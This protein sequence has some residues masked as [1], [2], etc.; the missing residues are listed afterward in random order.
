MKKAFENSL[1]GLMEQNEKIVL[2]TADEHSPELT[3]IRENFPLR[4]FSF[5]IAECNMVGAAAGL[6]RAGFVPLVYTVASFLAFRSFEFIR[7]DICINNFKVILVGYASGVKINNFGSVHHAIE[8]IA[9]L[10]ALPN[11]TLLSPASV[12]EVEPVLKAAL[13]TTAP[14]YIRLGK[15][16]EIE[17]FDAPPSFTIGKSEV[18]REGDDITIISTGNIISNAVEAAKLLSESGIEVELINLSSIKPLDKD[19]LLNSIRKTKHVLTLEEH[20]ITG[21]IGSLT[22][23]LIAENSVRCVFERMGFK[24]RFVTEYGWHKEILEQNGLSTKNVLE[25]VTELVIA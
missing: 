16:F 13:E 4:C 20:Q 8:D 23:E 3:T 24:D 9:V 14:V 18:I 1:L 5:G 19:T 10:R 22:A 15:G 12:N 25:K 7:C 17:I 2:L 21:G 11:L 6:S